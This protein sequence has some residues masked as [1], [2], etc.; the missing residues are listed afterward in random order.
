MIV[1]L[2]RAYRGKICTFYR[3]EVDGDNYGWVGKL[4]NYNRSFFKIE[5]LDG[6]VRLLNR[7]SVDIII[8]GNWASELEVKIDPNFKDKDSKDPE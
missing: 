2:L 7:K 5:G 1:S 3:K 6:R 8:K 4:Q